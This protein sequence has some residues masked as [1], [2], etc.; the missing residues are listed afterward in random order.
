MTEDQGA[1]KP[2]SVQKQPSRE[3]LFHRH[4]GFFLALFLVLLS[5][6]G[7][8][9]NHAMDLGLDR[10][11]MPK[12]LA[13]LF[14][15]NS[16]SEVIIFAADAR[17]ADGNYIVWAHDQA[18][19]N[20]TPIGS[21]TGSLIGSVRLPDELVIASSSEILLVTSD[22][23]LIERIGPSFLPGELSGL[24]V[25]EA[26]RLVLLAD[27]VLYGA[28]DDLTGFTEIDQKVAMSGPLNYQPESLA[29]FLSQID[30]TAAV[31]WQRFLSDLHTGRIFGSLVSSPRSPPHAGRR[32][33]RAAP[34]SAH[35]RSSPRRSASCA[36]R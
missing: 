6:T 16:S 26:E 36:L 1:R 18:Y 15:G 31:S 32:R 10:S 11:H 35:V 9:L 17:H 3:R 34:S 22:G 29:Q 13:A 27:G 12:R 24:G 21:L 25:S 20:R 5:A 30:Q 7:I 4:V 28:T 14:Y 8:V 23:Q 33:R 19:F 2:A